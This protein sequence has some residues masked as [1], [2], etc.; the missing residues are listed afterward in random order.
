MGWISW[1]S[2]FSCWSCTRSHCGCE[3]CPGLHLFSQRMWNPWVSYVMSRAPELRNCG[4]KLGYVSGMN[5]EYCRYLQYTFHNLNWTQVLWSIPRTAST[6]FSPDDMIA[7][8][9][10][11]AQYLRQID[12]PFMIHQQE[13][14][15]PTLHTNLHQYIK[16]TSIL[17]LLNRWKKNVFGDPF[18]PRILLR[19]LR[20]GTKNI[21]GNGLALLWILSHVPANS[22]GCNS[23]SFCQCIK[24]HLQAKRKHKHSNT[25]WKKQKRAKIS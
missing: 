7:V 25:P 11:W 8:C 22:Q 18:Q 2:L 14:T 19:W 21:L 10:G 16:P 24:T 4:R 6:H 13:S 1:S 9:I 12:D 23:W 5:I 20:Y 3:T 17:N 15:C